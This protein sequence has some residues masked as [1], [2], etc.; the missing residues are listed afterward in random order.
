MK[1]RYILW[2]VIFSTV[3]FVCWYFVTA[4]CAV[5]IHSNKE[6]LVGSIVSV[7]IDVFLMKP[8]FSISRTLLRLLAIEF[9][10]R[11]YFNLDLQFLF[12][13]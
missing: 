1:I 9:P 3:H 2:I 5:F 12:T 7:I 11:Y 10:N 6:W 13:G 4:F 8:I